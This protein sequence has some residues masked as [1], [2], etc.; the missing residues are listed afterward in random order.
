[1]STVG[2]GDIV[3]TTHKERIYVILCT[4]IA[5]GINYFFIFLGIKIIYIKIIIK[6]CFFKFLI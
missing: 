2:Y 4:F 3:A 1:M 5:C 6:K